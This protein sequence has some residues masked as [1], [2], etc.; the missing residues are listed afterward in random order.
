MHG[1]SAWELGTSEIMYET[2]TNHSSPVDA[3]HG[4][5]GYNRPTATPDSTHYRIDLQIGYV[6]KSYILEDN[7]CLTKLEQNNEPSK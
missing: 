5:D 2:N 7:S 6:R 3:G 1:Y 4:A